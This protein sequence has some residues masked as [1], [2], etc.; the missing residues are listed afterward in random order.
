MPMQDLFFFLR[1]LQI[2]QP[3]K[4]R[5]DRGFPCANPRNLR[6]ERFR[7]LIPSYIRDAAAA[8]IVYD[9]TRQA[10]F[11]G[12]R[13]D[14]N[15]RLCP[16]FVWNPLL[17]SRFLSGAGCQM[18]EQKE[19]PPFWRFLLEFSETFRFFCNWHGTRNKRKTLPIKLWPHLKE[20]EP[21]LPLLPSFFC[22][23]L[24]LPWFSGDG[25]YQW[26][27]QAPPIM[28]PPYGKLPILFPYHSHRSP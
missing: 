2:F 20:N 14:H 8:V 22:F 3:Q 13:T 26:E 17:A 18:S 4:S 16:A 6:Q 5:F 1:G 10:S 15:R 12:T 9:I 7:S 25:W 23:F 19:V 11:Q 24:F 28:W 21:R 27:F